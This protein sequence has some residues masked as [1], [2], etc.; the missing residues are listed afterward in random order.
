MNTPDSSNEPELSE[1]IAVYDQIAAAFAAR[2]GSLRLDRALDTFA[3]AV[4]NP[5][6]VLDLGC[7]PGRDMGFLTELGCQ[8]TG[9]DASAGM[10]SEARHVLPNAVLVQA[11]LRLPPF[12]AGSFDGV[13]ACASL[14]HLPHTALPHA[15]VTISQLLRWPGGVLYLALK[16]GTGEQW[17]AHAENRRLFFAYYQLSEIETVLDQAGFQVLESWSAPD[18][19]GRRQPWVNVVAA[20]SVAGQSVGL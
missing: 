13:W 2:W 11:N 15:L 6:R 8:V 9:L 14:V 5:R 18:L 7:G 19:S 16:G 12:A 17:V 20:L 1:T 4:P 10:V 3:Q